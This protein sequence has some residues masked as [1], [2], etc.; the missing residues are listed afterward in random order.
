[1]STF[2][3]CSHFHKPQF[4]L[5]LPHARWVGMLGV[6]F[7]SFG[8]RVSAHEPVAL[9]PDAVKAW[10]RQLGE[11]RASRRIEAARALAAL[12]PACLPLLPPV[13]HQG[14]NNDQR[15]S[16][17]E[18]V[19]ELWRVR[20]VQEAAAS[21]VDLEAMPLARA[22]PAIHLQTGNQVTD[23]R[24]WRGETVTDP[25]IPPLKAPFWSAL[26][27]LARHSGTEFYHFSDNRGVGLVAAN[28]SAPTGLSPT[29]ASHFASVQDNGA[30]R[31]VAAGWTARRDY[32]RNRAKGILHLQLWIEP[33]LTPLVVDV[34]RDQLK[35]RDNLNQPLEYLGPERQPRRLS[36]GQYLVPM[37]LS[38]SAP[39]RAATHI[40]R[41]EG[42]VGVWIPTIRAR[43]EFDN[44]D[45]DSG[46]R[47]LAGLRV[48]LAPPREVE[49]AWVFPLAKTV[50]VDPGVAESHLQ[51]ALTTEVFLLDSLGQRLA[52]SDQEPWQNAAGQTGIQ[53]IFES[54]PGKRAD[55]KLIVE[56]PVGLTRLPARFQFRDLPLP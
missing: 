31:F 36:D 52:P 22:L 35:A 7:A 41:L 11:P 4:A 24:S 43:F 44:L 5:G 51:A 16:L 17:R 33:R 14:L 25:V 3:Q 42:E 38:W 9:T 12:G 29:V 23:L 19:P 15:R 50:L 28:T 40:G 37:D 26:D 47:E 10:V 8:L 18:L 2:F 21:M 27:Q 32:T 1:M 48:R 6:L 54:I 46:T 45:R 20:R 56:W 39:P 30:F 53:Y 13:D 49:G 34:D 55:Y